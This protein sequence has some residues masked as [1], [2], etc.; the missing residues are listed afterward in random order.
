MTVFMRFLFITISTS[1]LFGL[2]FAKMSNVSIFYRC[3]GQITGDYAGNNKRLVD[4][5]KAGKDPVEVCMEVLNLAKL[6]KNGSSFDLSNKNDFV[7]KSVLKT[8]HNLHYSWFAN[9]GYPEV[10]W[11]GFR[12]YYN[13]YGS[14]V[15]ALYITKALFDP[16]YQYQ[17][18]V[19]G[20]D[21][22]IAKR[23][24]NTQYAPHP[25]PYGITE[26]TKSKCKP[27]A[28]YV[29][30][31]DRYPLC[32][33]VLKGI[34]YAMTGDLVGIKTLPKNHKLK[35]AASLVKSYDREDFTSSGSTATETYNKHWGGGM[36]GSTPY[37]I[38]NAQPTSASYRPDGGLRTYRKW[39]RSVFKDVLCRSL[40][41]V[42]ELDAAGIANPNSSLPFRKSMGCTKCHLSMDPMAG[43]VRDLRFRRIGREREKGHVFLLRKNKSPS[44]NNSNE[45]FPIHADSNYYKKYP[46]GGF[47][48]RNYNGQMIKES[49]LKNVGELGNL[50]SRQTDMYACLAKRY[51]KYF[52]G[53]DAHIGD[54][55]LNNPDPDHQLLN[56][57]ERSFRDLAIKLG[58]ELQNDQLQDPRKVIE[59][60]LRLPLYQESDYLLRGKK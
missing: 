4:K 56:P 11:N 20:E 58:K 22:F 39:S 51:L 35:Y 14:S 10:D 47:A 53:I 15:P 43:L 42:R 34:P 49:K 21:T 31:V 7:A 8:M 38:A 60:I 16:N 19:K 54:A 24:K 29:D 18:I 17:N 13:I 6:S 55:S 48:F 27:N 44:Y 5:V 36:I 52:T 30:R 26:A 12:N 46:S 33:W 2:S 37:F 9:K 57:K 23:T 41:V 3:Y 28:I 1:F 59:K 40:P 32:D 45:D 25:S 50:I